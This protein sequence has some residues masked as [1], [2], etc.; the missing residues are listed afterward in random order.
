MEATQTALSAGYA[1]MQFVQMFVALI[2]IYLCWWALQGLR[3]DRFVREPGSPQAKLLHLVLAVILGH[4]FSNF[5]LAYFTW[6]L[7]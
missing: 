5:L 3:F 2:S 4:Q 7:R 6:S 1:W